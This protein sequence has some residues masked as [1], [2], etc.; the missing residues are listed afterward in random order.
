MGCIYVATCKVNGKLYIGQ[1][2][3]RLDVRKKEHLSTALRETTLLSV[4]SIAQL[5]NTAQRHLN[6][7]LCVRLTLLSTTHWMN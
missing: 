2:R 3:T 5:S 7:M 1:T 4:F 6:G